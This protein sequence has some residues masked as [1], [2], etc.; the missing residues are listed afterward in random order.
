MKE[1]TNVNIGGQ[2]FVI[3]NDAYQLLKDYLADVRSRISGGVI[4]MK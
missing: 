1:T 4:L 2:A 3:D